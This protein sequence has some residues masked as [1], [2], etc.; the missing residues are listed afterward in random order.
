MSLP[1]PPP[2]QAPKPEPAP[3]WKRLWFWVI[4]VMVV[5]TWAGAVSIRM[6]LPFDEGA[7]HEDQ[8]RPEDPVLLAIDQE[9]G[10]GPVP[11]PSTC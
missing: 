4:V 1:M 6:A 7:S 11:E 8:H 3:I 9:L 10:E 5:G 2:P